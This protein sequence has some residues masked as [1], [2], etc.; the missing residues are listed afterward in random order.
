MRLWKVACGF[1]LIEIFFLGGSF[2]LFL[3]LDER[4]ALVSVVGSALLQ[5]SLIVAVWL[6]LEREYR[7]GR[8]RYWLQKQRLRSR[9][10]QT[11]IGLVMVGLLCVGRMAVGLYKASQVGWTR[12]SVIIACLWGAYAVCS[13]W[14]SISLNGRIVG[15]VAGTNQTQLSFGNDRRE[16]KY[17][18]DG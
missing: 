3:H 15:M 4:F 16:S 5:A 1:V 2:W 12:A 9:R 6:M 8:S 11:R 14:F 18:S 7:R 13:L 10:R 17:K